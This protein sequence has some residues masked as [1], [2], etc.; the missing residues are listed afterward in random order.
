MTMNAKV[1]LEL[2]LP[3][4]TCRKRGSMELVFIRVGL[5]LLLAVFWLYWNSRQYEK[6]L[7]T[8]VL[9]YCYC[10]CVVTTLTQLV[11]IWGCNK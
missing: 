9:D 10:G 3:P 7:R 2:I 11:D 6:Q 5:F 4:G 1:R 8:L